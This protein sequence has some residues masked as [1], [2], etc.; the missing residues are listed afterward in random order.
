MEEMSLAEAVV[1]AESFYGDMLAMLEVANHA[2]TMTSMVEFFARFSDSSPNI[3][4][5]SILMVTFYHSRHGTVLGKDRTLASVLL[6]DAADFGV[7][8]KLDVPPRAPDALDSK[9]GPP[10]DETAPFWCGF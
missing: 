7:P 5:S 4:P 3:V 9:D 2:G 1:A 6:N 10:A 8:P